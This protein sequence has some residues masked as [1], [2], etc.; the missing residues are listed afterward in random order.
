MRLIGAVGAGANSALNTEHSAPSTQAGLLAIGELVFT[1][2]NASGT[3]PRK[4]KVSSLMD[5]LCELE[6]AAGDESP[7]QAIVL[8]IMAMALFGQ[9]PNA[10]CRRSSSPTSTRAV[11]SPKR[12]SGAATARHSESG[13]ARSGNSR[14]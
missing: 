8:G 3:E 1:L 2:K 5:W 4:F 6:I 7:C 11:L 10:N 13:G 9:V 14:D 12:F